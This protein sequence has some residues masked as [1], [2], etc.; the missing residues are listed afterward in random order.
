M[1]YQAHYNKLITKAQNRTLP[2]NVYTEAHHILPR[3]MGGG[4]E[5]SNI[6]RLTLKEHYFAHILLAMAGNDNQWASVSAIIQDRVNKSKPQRFAKLK[7][8]K[9]IRRKLHSFATSRLRVIAA[10]RSRNKNNIR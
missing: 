4:D 7:L 5:P 1:D 3:S 9:F 8:S 6:I 2:I 10:Q